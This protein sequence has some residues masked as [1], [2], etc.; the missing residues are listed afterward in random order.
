MTVRPMVV[1]AGI[2]ARCRDQAAGD[3]GK[4]A[5]ALGLLVR[6]P[7]AV[8]AVL[9]AFGFVLIAVLEWSQSN[10]DRASNAVAQLSAFKAKFL[11]RCLAATRLLIGFAGRFPYRQIGQPAKH[12]GECQRHAQ[13]LPLPFNACLSLNKPPRARHIFCKV[14]DV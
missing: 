2:E 1:F 3:M 9:V 11:S 6:V 7:A 13:R 5:R 10:T 12:R 4:V 14:T 8:L